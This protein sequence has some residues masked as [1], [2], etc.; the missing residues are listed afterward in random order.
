MII[1]W[2]ERDSS[3]IIVPSSCFFL[4]FIDELNMV[5]MNDLFVLSKRN[6]D[7]IKRNLF[8]FYLTWC[9]CIFGWSSEWNVKLKS[10][11][12][13]IWLVE[14]SSNVKSFDWKSSNCLAFLIWIFYF[15]LN[16][17]D[18]LNKM[19]HLMI[20]DVDQM[21]INDLHFLCLMNDENSLLLL[22]FI[23]VNPFVFFFIS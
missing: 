16:L 19:S 20:E 1:G 7:F 8:D 5:L 10:S 17:Q 22:F 18:L 13:V 11:F 12:D 23:Y 6:K 21:M 2:L 9:F 4:N 14:H 15:L 3:T